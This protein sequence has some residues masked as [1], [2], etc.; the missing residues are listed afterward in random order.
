VN[1][2][3]LHLP[4]IG[5]FFSKSFSDPLFLVAGGRKPALSWM[6]CLLPNT[7]VWCADS[8]LLACLD[9]GILPQRLIGDGDSTPPEV[10]QKAQDDGIAVTRHPADKDL[11]DLQLALFTA[12]R[13]L[14]GIPVVVTG[15]W[16]GRFDHLWAN[17]FSALWAGERG[18]RILAFADDK[19]TLLL[20]GEGESLE[21]ELHEEAEA[22]ISLLPLSS[23]CSGVELSNVRWELKDSLLLQKHPYTVSNRPENKEN[24]S[25]SL[26]KGILG[27]YC[28]WL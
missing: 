16:G 11:T 17:V 21:I 8:G 27:V 25:V 1:G 2:S 26:R 18:V 20:L 14:A 5:A 24:I 22:V 10:W 19:E 3:S 4:G 15:C 9:A 13:E 7:V 12:G 6:Q 23:E 28:G